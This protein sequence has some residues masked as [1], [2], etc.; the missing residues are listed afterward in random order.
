MTDKHFSQME[1]LLVSLEQMSI[2]FEKCEKNSSLTELKEMLWVI[3]SLKIL[4][5]VTSEESRLQIIE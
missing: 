2:L 4:K 5:K 1:K 3:K